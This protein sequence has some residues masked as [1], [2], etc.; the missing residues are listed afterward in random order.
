MTTSDTMP[1]VPLTPTQEKMISSLYYK[2]G[3]TL[4]RTNLF[5]VLQAKH[6]TEAPSER[7]VGRWLKDQK[8]NQLFQPTRRSG[9][10]QSFKPTKPFYGMSADLIDFTNKQAMQYRYILVVIDNFS[11]F[12]F[13]E[14]MTSKEAS[15]TAKAMEKILDKVKTQFKAIPKY[16]L[17]DDGSEFK[18]DYITLLKSRGI[19]KRRTLGGQ[20]QSNGLVERANGK[21][22]QILMKNIKIFGGT[23]HTHLERVTKIYNDS[24]NRTIGFTP[25]QASV[26]TGK[27]AQ[28][29]RDNVAS[30]LKEENRTRPPDHKVGMKVRIKIAK[31]KLDKMSTPNWSESTYVIRHVIPGQGSKAPRYLIEGKQDDQQYTRND[32]QVIEGKIKDIPQTVKKSKVPTGPKRSQRLVTGLGKGG[33]PQPGAMKTRAQINPAPALDPVALVGA[34]I[35]VKW[36]N[37]GPLTKDALRDRG[38]IGTFYTGQLL[39]YSKTANTYKI[40]Y[41]DGLQD[42]INLNDSTRGDFV[43]T[44]YWR[45]VT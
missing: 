37:Q 39:S 38:K 10:V 32:I 43:S 4:G 31:G 20:P 16:V 21:L 30:T 9:A 36:D 27:G 11:R 29:L 44:D 40:K 6:K 3:Y 23:W 17:G 45:V 41:S 7:Q 34:K 15:K 19:E 5:E 13:T 24:P 22:K 8:L 35:K 12:M 1:P 18:G 33:Q 26:L 28:K 2:Q 25:E 14:A 42:F